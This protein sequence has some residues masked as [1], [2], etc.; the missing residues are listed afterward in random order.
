MRT[1]LKLMSGVAIPAGTFLAD[2]GNT[3][4]GLPGTIV[5]LVLSG[6]PRP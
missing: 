6:Q 3:S 2:E 4:R 1:K 5:Q